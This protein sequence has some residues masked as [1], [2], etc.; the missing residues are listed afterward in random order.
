M[1]PI[2]T[3]CSCIAS[4]SAA[5]TLAGARLISSARM[6]FAKIG[7]FLTLNVLRL[8]VVDL[9]ADHVGRQQVGREL[10]ARERRV[11][12]LGERAHR[13]RLGEAGHALEQDVA[14]G[15]Q[16]DEQPLDHRVLADD[17]AG[18]F[19]EDALHGQRLGR[20]VGQL[21]RAHARWLLRMDG[22]KIAGAGSLFRCATGAMR[23][24]V[25]HRRLRTRPVAGRSS[26]SA[27]FTGPITPGPRP[28]APPCTA[29]LP[30]S[31]SAG[32]TVPAAGRP[33]RTGPYESRASRST[34]RPMASPTGARSGC[35]PRRG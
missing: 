3:C 11:D 16:A 22:G 17:P 7:P 21:R 31:A 6:M 28:S 23:R 1:P 10:D 29:P 8:L 26:G 32:G 15:E 30:P 33:S 9:R 18:H 25:G 2:V 12:D 27:G 14:A 35:D 24:R 5:C 19:L 4:S 34:L 20:L 13:E